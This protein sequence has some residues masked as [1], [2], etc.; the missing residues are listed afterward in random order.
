MRGEMG[1][2]SGST[3]AMKM[4]CLRGRSGTTGNLRGVSEE[5]RGAGKSRH[6]C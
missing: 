1:P 3:G 6:R 2:G 4:L 5:A